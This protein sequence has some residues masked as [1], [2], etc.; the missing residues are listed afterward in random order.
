MDALRE[1]KRHRGKRVGG[2]W[3]HLGWKDKNWKGRRKPHWK[4]KINR[5]PRIWFYRCKGQ[6][7]KAKPHNQRYCLQKDGTAREK[8]NREDISFTY[9]ILS[10][11]GHVFFILSHLY[12]RYFWSP[13]PTIISW[14]HLGEVSNLKVSVK[15]KQVQNSKAHWPHLRCFETLSIYFLELLPLRR[16]FELSLTCFLVS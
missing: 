14:A 5:D 7:N 10:S 11:V 1:I 13:L 3:V 9:S 2:S 4:W 12:S 16:A 15:S 6:K 8:R